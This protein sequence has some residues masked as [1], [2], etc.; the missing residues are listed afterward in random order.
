M[1]ATG[2][3]GSRY[4]QALDDP[5]LDPEP[6]RRAIASRHGTRN[7]LLRE[8]VRIVMRIALVVAAAACTRA[9]PPAIPH[10]SGIDLVRATHEVLDA[11]DR[12]DLAAFRA[13]TATD[14]V[15]LDGGKFHDRAAELARM[16][17]HPPQVTRAWQ[18]ERLIAHAN[19]ATFIGHSIEHETGN[20]SHGN[21]A[22][23]GW[24]TVTWTRDGGAWKVAFWSWNRFATPGDAARAFWND[25]F[26][27]DIGFEHA[28]NRLLATTIEGLQPGAALDVASGQGRNALLLASRG[29]RV[30]ALDISDEGLARSR[31]AA[32]AAHLAVETVQADADV[33]DYGFAR[34]DLVTMIY[35]GDSDAR[36]KKIQSSLRPGGLFVAEYFLDEG[37]GGFKAG[38]LAKLFGDGYD[39]LR[40]E[41]V[42][43][44]PDWGVDRA[45]LVRFVARKR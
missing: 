28:P 21:R 8:L 1:T 9:T 2:I 10:S 15:R 39:I 45:K 18:D 43:D 22:F 42:E 11:F 41:V 30:T 44:R 38:Q 27:Q 4:L 5:I 6:R 13:A 31:A 26:R 40:D 33:Y 14:F 7:T 17:P 19:D 29:W 25:N 24:Y 35:A 34:W 36:L 20:D 3:T 37:D 23:D 12:G 32:S 16:K